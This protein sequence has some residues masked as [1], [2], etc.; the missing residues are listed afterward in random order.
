[1]SRRLR[2]RVD[3][4]Q[5]R[6]HTHTHTRTAPM[7]PRD[8]ER[9]DAH[10]VD[11]DAGERT[12]LQHQTSPPSSSSSHSKRRVVAICTL[13]ATAL[14]SLLAVAAGDAA[15]GVVPSALRLVPG[16][17]NVLQPLDQVKRFAGASVTTS[18]SS[19]PEYL[20]PWSEF[21][22]WNS[23]KNMPVY[24]TENADAHEVIVIGHS[25]TWDMASKWFASL[26]GK[27]VGVKITG[28]NT[29]YS[30]FADKLMGLRAALSTTKGD[31]L[32]VFSDVTDVLFLCKAGELLNRFNGVPGLKFLS[33]SQP[34]NWPEVPGSN[35][36]YDMT[37]ANAFKDEQ[38]QKIHAVGLTKGFVK[39]EHT[40][41]ERK[42]ANSG[43]F[44]AR[45]QALET[46][47]DHVE[48]DLK[49]GMRA[50]KPYGMPTDDFLHGGAAKFDDQLCMNSYLQ[51]RFD[52]RDQGVF[53]DEFG[54]VFL[55]TGDGS[56]PKHF[57]FPEYNGTD[58]SASDDL[59][60]IW[61]KRTGVRPCAVHFNGASHY[62]LDSVLNVAPYLAPEAYRSGAA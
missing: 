60:K 40:G 8:I 58:R 18:T 1:M 34:K 13:G 43:L 30:G 35:R 48:E 39:K 37:D 7:P 23:H 26:V 47:L 29:K 38:S 55:S 46:Y 61:Y 27:N 10:V 56:S 36:F 3:H 6:A 14:V 42:W 52:Q 5:H 9:A 41:S 59:T 20:R 21:T 15:V 45:R 17:E 16:T 44:A 22:F 49:L 62:V 12:P 53:L 32:F 31:H 54:A 57:I 25:T 28:L 33:S 2:A 24:E 19:I 11:A 50:C 4:H 51:S